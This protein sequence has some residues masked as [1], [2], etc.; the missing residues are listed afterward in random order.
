MLKM[1]VPASNLDVPWIFRNMGVQRFLWTLKVSVITF[2]RMKPQFLNKPV[3]AF[4]ILN[5]A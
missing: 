4:L 2:L 3:S 1:S 5:D